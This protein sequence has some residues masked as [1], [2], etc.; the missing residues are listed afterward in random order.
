MKMAARIMALALAGLPLGAAVVRASEPPELR[1]NPFSR[2]PSE[3][4][5]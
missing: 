2:P 3:R 5:I 1:H 4:T